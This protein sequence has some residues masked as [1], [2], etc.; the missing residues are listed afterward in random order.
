MELL[1]GFHVGFL[2]KSI[3]YA[4]IILF[5]RIIEFLGARKHAFQAPKI[6]NKAFYLF[7]GLKT[8]KM[9]PVFSFKY[10]TLVCL[11]SCFLS[12]FRVEMCIV[13]IRFPPLFCFLFIVPFKGVC[14]PEENSLTIPNYYQQQKDPCIIV[15][16]V[17]F[18]DVLQS[19]SNYWPKQSQTDTRYEPIY[20]S[21]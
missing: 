16:C 4:L 15:K 2:H 8:P 5:L 21:V 13:Y 12:I 19:I 9:Q 18:P 7:R 11:C 6:S 3:K 17:R 14:V 1:D 10:R 20:Q